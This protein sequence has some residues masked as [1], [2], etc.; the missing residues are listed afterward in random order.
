[1]HETIEYDDNFGN[2]KKVVPL[3]DAL[4]ERKGVCKEKA[5]LLTMILNSEGFDAEYVKDTREENG[6][7]FGHAWVKVTYGGVTKLAAPTNNRLGIYNRAQRYRGM[8]DTTVLL[9]QYR[10]P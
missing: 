7:N 5:A 6:T 4:R 2:G 10:G 1:M 3:Y 8:H 9:A